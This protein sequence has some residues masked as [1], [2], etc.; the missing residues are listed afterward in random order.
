MKTIEKGTLV[1]FIYNDKAMRGKV[2]DVTDTGYI[3]D[4]RYGIYKR[5]D[6]VIL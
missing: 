4:R 6:L 1:A 3:V 5:S 2:S